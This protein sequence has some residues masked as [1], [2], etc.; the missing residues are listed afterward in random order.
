[1]AK[2]G[3][4][5]PERWREALQVWTEDDLIK[6][7]WSYLA[8]FFDEAAGDVLE[9]IADG[10][11]RWLQAVAKYC[12]EHEAIFLRLCRRILATDCSD[13]LEQDDPVA[14]AINHPV[15]I[16]TEALLLWWY[17]KSPKDDDGLPDELR[18]T[19][20]ALCDTQTEKFRPGRVLLAAHIIS[21]FRVDREWATDHL[22]PLFDWRQSE[23][24]A[25]SAWMAFLWSPRLHRPLLSALKDQFLETA[26]HYHELGEASDE[27]ASFLTYVALDPGDIF[28]ISE[29]AEV[30]RQLPTDGLESAA[31]LLGSA[32][33]NAGDQRSEYLRNR[34]LPYVRYVWPNTIEVRTEA[35]SESFARL[36][37]VAGEAFP[38]ALAELRRWLQP[39]VHPD[40]VVHLLLEAGLCERIPQEAMAFL[41]A[42]IGDDAFRLPSELAQCLDEIQRANPGIT[43]DPCF[44]RLDELRRRRGAI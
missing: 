21:L 25:K 11:S 43:A 18:A 40:Y 42:V 29:L 19:F 4:W 8:T 1:L 10:F 37:V 9:S 26:A 6:R 17:R 44:I 20:T 31:R 39:L 27:F 13:E 12:D 30:T 35:I 41:D 22:L 15:G 23:A 14:Q 28:S 7:S 32:L 36:C 38:E 16:I 5:P 3:V 2:E 33:E 34:I 24:E